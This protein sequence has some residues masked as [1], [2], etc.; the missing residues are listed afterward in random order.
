LAEKGCLAT[1]H[2]LAI[3]ERASLCSASEGTVHL[4]ST[5]GKPERDQ[6]IRLYPP[7]TQWLQGLAMSPE[8][9]HLAVANP[10]GTVAILRLAER[11][12][13]FEPTAP[14]LQK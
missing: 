8:G 2:G 1:F 5:G 10:D 9:R 6:V 3:R 13:V 4:W 12:K 7:E 14:S 11:G